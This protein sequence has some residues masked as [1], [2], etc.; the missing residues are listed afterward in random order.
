[1]P[2]GP[3]HPR[4]AGDGGSPGDAGLVHQPRPEA[5]IGVSRVPLTRAEHAQNR[6]PRRRQDRVR[7]LHL[8]QALR[9]LPGGQLGR[10]RRGHEG[11]P[12]PH[13]FHRLADAGE[14]RNGSHLGLPPSR[15]PGCLLGLDRDSRP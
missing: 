10:V 7:L 12:G 5:V 11:Q 15:F 8:P 13:H 14:S 2:G 1:M 3:I 6:G 4:G 9:L